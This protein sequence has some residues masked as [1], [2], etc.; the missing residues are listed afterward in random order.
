M[1]VLNKKGDVVGYYNKSHLVPF[2]EYIPLRK[3]L[4]NFLQPVANAIGEFGK[5]EGPKIVELD[6]LPSIGGIICYEVIFPGKI[7]DENLRPDFLV[8]LTNDGWYGDSF[9][10]YQ[11]FVATKMR[12]VEEGIT[13]I[14]AA[15]NGISGMI[16]P[17]GKE[18]GILP[19]NYVGF[20]DVKL[21]KSLHNKTIYASFD[22]WLIVT[23]CLILLFLGIIRIKCGRML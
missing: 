11:H 16:T 9:G 12:A 18:K 15:N 7:V 17:L 23:F 10:P 1:I 19:L 22:N 13:I 14:R 3:Y 8:N 20:S 4:P 5:G 21:V 2:G 6:G